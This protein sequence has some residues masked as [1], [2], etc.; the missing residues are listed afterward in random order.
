MNYE[1]DMTLLSFDECDALKVRMQLLGKIAA[2][3]EWIHR[4]LDDE[5]T[6]S[7]YLHDFY[8]LNHQLSP[9]NLLSDTQLYQGDEAI[10]MRSLLERVTINK[11]TLS[12]EFKIS[13]PDGRIKWHHTTIHPITDQQGKLLGL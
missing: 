1:L 2:V 4:F 11:V 7:D 12:D 9:S 3:G 6:W 5:I 13:M 10:K 8:E